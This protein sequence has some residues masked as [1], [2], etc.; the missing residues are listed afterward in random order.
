MRSSTE[1]WSLTHDDPKDWQEDRDGS[2]INGR[3]RN[4]LR[5]SKMAYIVENVMSQD[6]RPLKPLPT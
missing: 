5:L 1:K 2:L 3:E 4:R 6:S